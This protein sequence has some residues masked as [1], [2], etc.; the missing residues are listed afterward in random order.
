[1][2]RDIPDGYGTWLHEME[3]AAMR[4]FVA[5]SDAW[6][7]TETTF[8]KRALDEGRFTKLYG[9]AQKHEARVD[10]KSLSPD[11]ATAAPNTLSPTTAPLHSKLPWRVAFD[12]THW[13]IFASAGRPGDLEPA[14]AASTENFLP[15]YRLANAKFIVRACNAHDDLLKALKLAED[16]VH[17]WMQDNT[18]E[19][20]L[21]ALEQI[22]AA[23]AKAEGVNAHV[24]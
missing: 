4:G 8:R 19:P 16:Y 7:Q 17:L 2:P 5:L 3:K 9:L 14:V 20:E 18:G 10:R 6:D 24:A 13:M 12:G 1:M 11:E 23:I 15:K 21:K 22:E